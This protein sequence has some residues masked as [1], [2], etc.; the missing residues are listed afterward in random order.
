MPKG[1]EMCEKKV[2]KK[3]VDVLGLKERWVRVK[4]L[5]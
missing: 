5:K 2:T 1:L 4:E 3:I